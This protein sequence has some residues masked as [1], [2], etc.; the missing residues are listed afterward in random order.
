VHESGVNLA[1]LRA[2]SWENILSNTFSIKR[3]NLGLFVLPS[4]E[5]RVIHCWL[6]FSAWWEPVLPSGVVTLLMPVRLVKSFGH[7][8]FYRVWAITHQAGAL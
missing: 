7:I 1:L 2:I 3:M 5:A 4:S 8:Q 6:I